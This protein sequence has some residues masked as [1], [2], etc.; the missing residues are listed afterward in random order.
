MIVRPILQAILPGD[1]KWLWRR[2]SCLVSV[3]VF[4]WCIVTTVQDH[5]VAS[6]G[7]CVTGLLGALGIYCGAGVADDHLKRKTECEERHFGN[8]PRPEDPDGNR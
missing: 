7:Q 8:G 5:D 6:L 1:D 2:T 4:L 3:G